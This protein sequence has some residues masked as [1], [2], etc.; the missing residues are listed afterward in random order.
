MHNHLVLHHVD[1]ALLFFEALAGHLH[2]LLKELE[3]CQ[4]EVAILGLTLELSLLL[5][6]TDLT[7]LHLVL[8]FLSLLVLLLVVDT[9]LL[10]GSLPFYHLIYHFL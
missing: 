8:E 2:V 6:G 9:V 3:L 5:G 4:V 10:T 1:L 7:E